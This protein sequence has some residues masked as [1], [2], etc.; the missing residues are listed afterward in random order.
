MYNGK[1][2]ALK[3]VLYLSRCSA[4]VCD[5]AMVV[6]HIHRWNNQGSNGQFCRGSADV[7]H[8]VLVLMFAND[9]VYTGC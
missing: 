8:K 5:V 9:I 1:W 4:R 7:K 3:M 6:K 2:K